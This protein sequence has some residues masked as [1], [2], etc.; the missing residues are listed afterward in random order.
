MTV[1]ALIQL[2]RDLFGWLLLERP[3][4]GWPQYALLRASS[5]DGGAIV[6][7]DAVDG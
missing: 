4:P 7:V 6:T 3:L 5:G 1:Q 2:Y